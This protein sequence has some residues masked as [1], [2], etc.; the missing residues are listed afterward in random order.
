MM[1]HQTISH[2]K[3]L[4]QLGEGGI[5]V[6]WSIISDFQMFAYTSR[7]DLWYCGNLVARDFVADIRYAC[8]EQNKAPIAVPIYR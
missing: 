2:Y 5:G 7:Q 3:I 4:G 1:N 8:F 6:A